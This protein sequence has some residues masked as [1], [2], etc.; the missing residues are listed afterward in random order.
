MSEKTSRRK[1]IHAAGLA[2]TGMMAVAPLSGAAPVAQQQPPTT[3]SKGARFRELL[4]R[5]QTFENI[6]IY[7][8]L[9]ARLVEIA[10]F[11]SI[12]IGGTAVSQFHGMP[13]NLIS[14]A[15]KVAFYCHIA[16]NVDIP[17]VA[18][19]TD[20]SPM[21]LYRVVKELERGEVAAIHF[22]DSGPEGIVPPAKMID[23]IHAAVDARSDLAI[24]VRTYGQMFESTEKAIERGVAY[25]EAGADTIW[26]RSVPFENLPRAADRVKIPLTADMEGTTTMASAREAR[27]VVATYSS[28]IQ[29]IAQGAVYNAV[30]E[31]KNTGVLVNSPNSNRAPADVRSQMMRQDEFA[32]RRDK[33]ND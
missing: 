1:F 21:I 18:D 10:G 24:S 14:V 22:E 2:A 31:L 33:Y 12:Y 17:A 6:A 4:R 16:K 7:D 30:M 5:R 11:P 19:I 3:E 20:D 23:K 29:G 27:V 15:E 13:E 9:S 26:L 28:L 8:V 25:G 32:A